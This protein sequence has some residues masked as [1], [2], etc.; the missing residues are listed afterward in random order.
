[1]L[2]AGL[3]AVDCSDGQPGPAAQSSLLALNVLRQQPFICTLKP[4]LF[5]SQICGVITP[6]S[7]SHTFLPGLVSQ[8]LLSDL[9]SLIIGG[10][11]GSI[12]FQC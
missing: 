3:L 8:V 2:V 7:V 1:M 10:R 12:I 4:A 6:V 9:S 5:V 11:R